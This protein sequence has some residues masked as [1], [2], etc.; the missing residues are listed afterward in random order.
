[1]WGA[2]YGLKC[3]YPNGSILGSLASKLRY[4]APEFD[5]DQIIG[6]EDDRKPE[7]SHPIASADESLWLSAGLAK[8][9]K[10]IAQT[11]IYGGYSA[12]LQSF[13]MKFKTT[14]I[15]I[16]QNHSYPY[17]TSR[18]SWWAP[19]AAPFLV[20]SQALYEITNNS[21]FEQNATWA[22]TAIS[23][24]IQEI[25]YANDDLGHIN[26][27][28]GLMLEWTLKNG[29]LEAINLAK[30]AI[31]ARYFNVWNHSIE[32]PEN[33]FKLMKLSWDRQWVYF[34]ENIGLNAHL[35]YSVYA[36][37]L[38]ARILNTSESQTL[39]YWA[40]KQIDWILGIN[41]F[42]ICMIENIGHNNLPAYH[43]RF[44]FCRDNPRGA[45]PGAVPN[46]YF[47]KNGMP[48]LDLKEYPVGS[49]M[50]QNVDYKSNE[51]WLPHNVALLHA[52]SSRIFL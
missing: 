29:T 3:I 22:A 35:L 42:G 19:H 49:A 7:E 41:P 2:L 31:Q 38:S 4:V 5:T 46:G 1:M 39:L 34:T 14:A 52:L 27:A 13:Y 20:A 17:N 32:D 33:I 44:M 47:L 6:T 23:R 28:F 37:Q 24:N 12:D 48:Y 8:F 18:N 30:E 21:A 50:I 51:P 10:I 26:R 36:M 16:Y 40:N 45:V 15:G 43:H 9:A 25:V 11:G